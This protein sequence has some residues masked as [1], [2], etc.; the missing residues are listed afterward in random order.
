MADVQGALQE[1]YGKVRAMETVDASNDHIDTNR[2]EAVF[3][4]Y[5]PLL[6][7]CSCQLNIEMTL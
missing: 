3:T 5:V 4:E 6:K 1:T 7:N 2:N